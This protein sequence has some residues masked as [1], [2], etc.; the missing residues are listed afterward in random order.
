MQRGSEIR[1]ERLE[2]S[3]LPWYPFIFL[4]TTNDGSGREQA[5]GRVDVLCGACVD[6]GGEKLACAFP[7][8][9]QTLPGSE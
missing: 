7:F 4:E 2:F 1:F 5:H 3:G 8:R 6:A 9:G